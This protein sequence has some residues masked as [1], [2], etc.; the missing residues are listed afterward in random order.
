MKDPIH[1]MVP[2]FITHIKTKTQTVK[3]RTR[4]KILKTRSRSER[5]KNKIEQNPD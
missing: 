2:K 4:S 3:N 1:T 5:K